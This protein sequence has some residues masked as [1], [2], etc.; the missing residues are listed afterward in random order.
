MSVGY[1]QEKVEQK[2]QEDT[3]KNSKVARVH[4]LKQNCSVERNN[5]Q[6]LNKSN[7]NLKPY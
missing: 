6:G 7:F 2:I 5:I 3:L 4:A 1:F